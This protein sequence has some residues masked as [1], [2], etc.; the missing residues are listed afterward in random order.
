MRG[1]ASGAVLRVRMTCV[2]AFCAART[3]RR[4]SILPL[5]PPPG[6]QQVPT[7]RGGGGWRR[8][9][10]PP[11]LDV[12]NHGAQSADVGIAFSDVGDCG[13]Q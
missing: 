12:S 7:R 10:P 1:L 11:K 2:F 5:P 13:A 8:A 9:A 4:S 3:P 6:I